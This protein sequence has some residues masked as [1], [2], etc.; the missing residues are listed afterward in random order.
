MILLSTGGG[1]RERGVPV[2]LTLPVL[3]E[4]KGSGCCASSVAG[5]W[6]EKNKS[7]TA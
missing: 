5:N 7:T 4:T 2:V 6:P 1:V 3:L